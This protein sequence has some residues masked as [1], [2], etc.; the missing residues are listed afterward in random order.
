MNTGL[1]VAGIVLSVVSLVFLILRVV[2]L[3]VRR[4]LE[5]T[6][7]SRFKKEEMLGATTRA[8]FLGEVSRGGRQARGNGALVLTRQALF[9][10]RA[11]P[12][13]EYEIPLK[14]ITGISIVRSFNGRTVMGKILRVDFATQKGTDAMGWAL[15]D[16]DRWKLSL[17][18]LTL[19]AGQSTH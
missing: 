16:A 11:M 10:I 9:F 3:Q 1:F 2:F 13:K 7:A 18:K 6:V 8:V 12:R 14:A 15:T 19:S 17:E 5:K 4:K